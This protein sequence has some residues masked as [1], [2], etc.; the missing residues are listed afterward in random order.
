MGGGLLITRATHHIMVAIQKNC[1]FSQNDCISFKQICFYTKTISKHSSHSL[2][3]SLTTLHTIALKRRPWRAMPQ[4]FHSTPAAFPM[5]NM[6]NIPQESP[7]SK[8][9]SQ[10]AKTVSK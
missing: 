6:P 8:A 5:Q 7:N 3:C 9:F 2:P 10:N 4:N 1:S